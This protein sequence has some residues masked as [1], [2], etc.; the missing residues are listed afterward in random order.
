ML[1]PVIITTRIPAA[2]QSL[3][4]GLT[5][6]RGGSNIPQTPTKVM[7]KKLFRV[8]KIRFFGKIKL[9]GW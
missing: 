6:V 8:G 2:L 9:L 5:S 4:A 7:S 1:S 3:M